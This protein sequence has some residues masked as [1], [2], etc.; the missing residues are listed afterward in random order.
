MVKTGIRIGESHEWLHLPLDWIWIC[1]FKSKSKTRQMTTL[2]G[3]IPPLPTS[4]HPD[5]ELHPEMIRENILQLLQHDLAGILV[6]GSNGELVM[7]T[8]KEKEQVYAT[9]R[10]AIPRDK[11]MIAG[12]GG[13]STRETIR[14]SGLAA[15]HGAD[16][17][18]VL[19][20]FYYKGQMSGDVLVEHYHEVA[21]NS[22]IPVIIYNMP[23][24]SGIDMGAETILRISEHPNITGL[25]DS[26]GDIP[27][28]KEVIRDA[29]EDFRVM[30]GSA[31][32][33]LP[34][35]EAGAKGG[36]LALANIFPGICLEIMD[37]YAE[38]ELEKAQE[39]QLNVIRLNTAVTRQWGVPGLKSA[40]DLLGNYGGPCRKPLRDLDPGRKTELKSLIRDVGSL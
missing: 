27:K 35:L 32:F 29:P 13:Q 4:F 16:A 38:G 18:L 8:E 31:G 11:L 15:M 36:I 20:P 3:I 28:M 5:E 19:N 40:M 2:K 12:T 23:A 37:L 26:G 34:A 7:L 14:L 9:A 33:L 30:A 25:K 1:I 24:N 22:E 39:L 6:L 21:E 17:V 10:E